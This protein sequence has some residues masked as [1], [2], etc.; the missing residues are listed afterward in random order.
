M[1]ENTQPARP[2]RAIDIHRAGVARTLHRLCRLRHRARRNP[3]A[4]R[5]RLSARARSACWP[6][7][8][9]RQVQSCAAPVSPSSRPATSWCS[10]GQPLRP[11]AIYDTNGAIA[12]AAIA[13]NGG[14]AV[15]RY[16]PRRRNGARGREAQGA[17]RY[18]SRGALRRH[19]E[20]RGRRLAPH[21]R[22]RLGKP[23]ILAHGVKAR[24][25]GKPICL[26]VCD[27]KPV[28][29]LPG[30]PTSAMFTFHT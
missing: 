23:G 29:I 4:R 15:R 12:T 8:A 17:R 24:K 7:A 28:V 20:R 21:H 6:P 22:S 27:G 9:L 13:E 30:F 5:Y 3:A 2:A 26:A 1:V 16:H 25:P 19:V 10:P 11:A 14:E 18:R